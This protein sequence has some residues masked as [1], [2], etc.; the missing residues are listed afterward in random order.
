MS[1]VPLDLPSQ[2]WQ[3]GAAAAKLHLSAHL[4]LLQ[5]STLSGRRSN[6]VNVSELSTEPLP[7]LLCEFVCPNRAALLNAAALIRTTALHHPRLKVSQ[8]R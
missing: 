6:T 3:W 4:I 8:H 2:P 5:L 7:R 1:G